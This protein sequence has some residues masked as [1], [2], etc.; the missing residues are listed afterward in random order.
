MLCQAAYALPRDVP[1]LINP[2]IDTIYL[3]GR[4]Q[5]PLCYRA[6]FE[7][8]DVDFS[9]IRSVAVDVGWSRTWRTGYDER[10]SL[11]E[12]V[13]RLGNVRRLHLVSEY[14]LFNPDIRYDYSAWG[15]MESWAEAD[16]GWKWVV[17]V[18]RDLWENVSHAKR[19]QE[20][21]ARQL[22]AEQK[23]YGD[24]EGVM[25]W[26][27]PEVELGFVKFHKFPKVP[28]EFRE[29]EQELGD[30]EMMKVED[31]TSASLWTKSKRFMADKF[32][33]QGRFGGG[34]EEDMC[35]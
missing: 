20:T 12:I 9:L 19:W 31:N 33:M 6:W 17:P 5:F 1:L 10:I 13:R 24:V 27:V 7:R 21:V 16:A 11:E 25:P 8:S 22:E 28:R 14:S 23:R 15:K 4:A 32:R 18:D 3:P 26:V 29:E 30:F 34:R 2:D 35:F